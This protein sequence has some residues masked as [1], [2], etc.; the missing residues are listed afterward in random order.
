MSS[1]WHK[2][3][4]FHLKLI[5]IALCCA[6]Y[7]HSVKFDASNFLLIFCRYGENVMEVLHNPNWACPPCRDICNCSRC[8]RGKGWMPTGNI[9]NKVS[10][11][12]T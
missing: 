6:N 8:R 4:W 9:Y 7:C 3:K 11:C 12:T 2:N 10:Y 1:N 5:T